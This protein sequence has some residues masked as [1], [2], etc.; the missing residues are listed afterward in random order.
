MSHYCLE[1][2]FG[3]NFLER[4]RKL[5]K[6]GK[7]KRGSHVIIKKCKNSALLGKEGRRRHLCRFLLSAISFLPGEGGLKD[8]SAKIQSLIAIAAMH[9]PKNV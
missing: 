1:F 9:Y 2:H 5:P 7:E 8:K 3:N 4:L 6:G